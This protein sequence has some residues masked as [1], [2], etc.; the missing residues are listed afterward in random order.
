[1]SRQWH[2]PLL[3]PGPMGS[4]RD[5]SRP[6]PCDVGW[7]AIAGFF[8]VSET[9][10]PVA[11]TGPTVRTNSLIGNLRLVRHSFLFQFHHFDL[12]EFDHGAGVVSL[13]GEVALHVGL[14]RVRPIHRGLTVHFDG[15]AIVHHCQDRKSTRLNSSHSQISY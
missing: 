6:G 8:G 7:G 4:D 9:V 5:S 15:N 2:L 1:M 11:N 13:Q 3:P 12:S 14:V 10:G